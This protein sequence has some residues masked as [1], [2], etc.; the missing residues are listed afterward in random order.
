MLVLRRSHVG[1]GGEQEAPAVSHLGLGSWALNK[2][3]NREERRGR[4]VCLPYLPN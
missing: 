2:E 3:M 4:G 1:S